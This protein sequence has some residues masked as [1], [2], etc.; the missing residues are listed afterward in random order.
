[1]RFIDTKRFS[2]V[3]N[4]EDLPKANDLLF[5]E[6]K[7]LVGLNKKQR[8]EYHADNNIVIDE[9][10]WRRQLYRC[11][12]G[13]TVQNAVDYGGDAIVDGIDALWVGDDCYLPE[14]DL[15]FKNRAV[16]ISGRYY[17]YLNFWRI[18]G[19]A[20]GAVTKTLIKPKFLMLDVMYSF[21]REMMV[22]FKKDNQETKA[23]QIGFSE[24]LAGMDLAYNYLFLPM[25][26]NIIVA[27]E[28]TDADNTFNN[29]TR[30]LDELSNTQFYLQRKRGFD[31]KKH[32]MSLN[33]SEVF[34]E[35][36]NDDPQA[37]SRY[38]PT[39]IVYEEVGKGKKGWSLKVQ[40]YAAPSLK[41]EDKKTGYQLF[42]GTGGEMEEGVYDLQ[43]RAYNPDRHN[44][45]SFTNK[46]AKEGYD[47]DVKVAHFNPKWMYKIVDSDGNAL[48]AESIAAIKKEA[49]GKSEEQKYTHQST[50]AIFLDDVFQSTTAGYLGPERRRLLTERYNYILTHKDAQITRKGRLEWKKAGSIKDGVYFVDATEDELMREDWW[51]EIVEEPEVN[52]DGQVYVNLYMQGTDTYNQDESETSDSLGAVTVYKKW[53]NKS[54]SPFFNTYVAL[55]LERPSI[56]TGGQN[57]FFEHT[58]MLSIYY[59][60]TNNIEFVNPFIFEY[61]EKMG[62]ANMLLERPSLAF[63]GQIKDNKASNR[64]GTDKALKPYVLSNFRDMMD[65]DQINRLW[66]PRQILAFSKFKYRPGRQYNC[67]ITMASAM[68]L[69]AFKETELLEI[70]DSSLKTTEPQY[71]W[72]EIDGCLV[73]MAI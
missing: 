23:R 71:V 58:L 50:E 9:E 15:T 37:L 26:Q 27:G 8:I 56:G 52:L 11:Y 4:G 63:A 69:I 62:K 44:I 42:I 36:A 45:L 39:L 72:K 18:R 30:G 12:Y 29:V 3:A 55:L 33:G 31:N 53:R 38:A 25:S 24:K 67:D 19:L 10:W 2:P 14:Y 13:Y 46:W 5:K 16:H 41:V 48:K 43:E 70:Q 61:Y 65:E 22:R 34:T 59:N 20:D 40:R 17:F 28:Q 1:M 6:A 47:G 68:A 35:N 21:R 64:Y 49:E 32:I 51:L 66:I 54:E 7:E 57:R 73:R 60:S